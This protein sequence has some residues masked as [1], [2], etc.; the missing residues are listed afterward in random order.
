MTIA[1]I[2]MTVAASVLSAIGEIARFAS[3]EQTKDGLEIKLH[4][5]QKALENAERLLG[6]FQDKLEVTGKLTLEELVLQAMA[7]R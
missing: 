2:N 4:D 7:E 5:Q 1:G 6:M 3:A